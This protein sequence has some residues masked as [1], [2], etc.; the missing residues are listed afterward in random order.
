MELTI[1]SRFQRLPVSTIFSAHTLFNTKG[2]VLMV[3]ISFNILLF[4]RR[5]VG[6][7][8]VDIFLWDFFI[9]GWGKFCSF[10]GGVAFCLHFIFLTKNKHSDY[11]T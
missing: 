4:N 5:E 7:E 10:V 9:G 2:T 3:C 8:I 6:W 1:I 11:E